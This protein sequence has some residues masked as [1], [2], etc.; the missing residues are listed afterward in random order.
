MEKGRLSNRCEEAKKREAQ[1]FSHSMCRMS[2][3]SRVKTS[4]MCLPMT[5]LSG[6]NRLSRRG[7]SWLI[8]ISGSITIQN[9]KTLNK[10]ER[11]H[12]IRKQKSSIGDLPWGMSSFWCSAVSTVSS[13]EKWYPLCLHCWSL[14]E[15]LSEY[16]KQDVWALVMK[17]NFFLP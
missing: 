16:L 14:P 9:G 2:G 8:R 17:Y 4:L 5:Q 13:A 11:D 12:H 6:S 10:R 7:P 3:L 15:T 1:T